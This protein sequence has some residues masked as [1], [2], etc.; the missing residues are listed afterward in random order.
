MLL[1]IRPTSAP[2]MIRFYDGQQA[3]ETVQHPFLACGVHPTCSVSSI[4][5]GPGSM[6]PS[7]DAKRMQY[8][9]PGCKSSIS[10][11]VANDF[12]SLLA[13]DSHGC[14]CSFHCNLYFA[15]ESGETNSTFIVVYSSRFRN[16]ALVRFVDPT[17][18]QST[19]LDFVLHQQL[20]DTI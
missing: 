13:A 20:S 16:P 1:A 3:H 9:V 18:K 17:T 6:L 11:E 4:N 8:V 14:G 7:I 19:R 2:I 12:N 15:V 5:S 10:A